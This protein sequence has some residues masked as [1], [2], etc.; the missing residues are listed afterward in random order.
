MFQTV[1]EGGKFIWLFSKYNIIIRIKY[2]NIY[3]AI[4]KFSFFFPE[5]TN[6]LFDQKS[7]V[8]T[9]GT[10]NESWIIVFQKCV[11]VLFRKKFFFFFFERQVCR[12][13][14]IYW[15]HFYFCFVLANYK[16]GIFFLF[17]FETRTSRIPLATTSLWQV[18]FTI[19]YLFI[20]I[21]NYQSSL[22]EQ[23]Q[24]PLFHIR[25]FVPFGLH[26]TTFS[27]SNGNQLRDGKT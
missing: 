10:R 27:D 19:N 17:F 2:Y 16:L 6:C 21:Q 18:T 8:K 13:I 3:V 25:I 22:W 1:P 23:Q 14:S 26:P 20:D 4:S 12:Y 7:C 9:T 5:N 15:I 11:T 24:N